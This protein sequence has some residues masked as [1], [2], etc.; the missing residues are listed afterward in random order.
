MVPT[1][2]PV[3]HNQC[4]P[5]A[6]KRPYLLQYPHAAAS[7]IRVHRRDAVLP[8][9]HRAVQLASSAIPCVIAT[10]PQH[11]VFGHRRKKGGYAWVLPQILQLSL[12]RRCSVGLSHRNSTNHL[13]WVISSLVFWS[14]R[15]LAA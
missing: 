1:I 11:V 14:G 4:D 7:V 5:D 13:F 2:R 12:L 3:L 8:Q 10:A 9:P 15:T 6:K